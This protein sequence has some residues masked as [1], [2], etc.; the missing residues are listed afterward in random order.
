MDSVDPNVYWIF[1]VDEHS[2]LIG[3]LSN[4]SCQ[5]VTVAEK[6]ISVAFDGYRSCSKRVTS[7]M[8]EWKTVLGSP[9][10]QGTY[11]RDGNLSFVLHEKGTVPPDCTMMGPMLFTTMALPSLQLR[12]PEGVALLDAYY[13][14]NTTVNMQCADW[15][16]G[17]AL[18]REKSVDFIL[19]SWLKTKSTSL[20]DNKYAFFSPSALCY[21]VR[22]RV[23]VPPSFYNSWILFFLCFI[24]LVPFCFAIIFTFHVQRATRPSEHVPLSA[25]IMFFVMTFLGRSPH[26]LNVSAPA[27]RLVLVAWLLLMFFIGNYL[28]SSLTASRSMPA[29][30][31]EITKEQLLK[32]LQEG[33]ML[34]CVASFSFQMRGDRET[35]PVFKPLARALDK[36]QSRCL[37]KYGFGCMKKARRGTDVYF[38]MCVEKERRLAFMHGLV[39]GE[40]SLAAWQTYSAVHIRFPLRYQHKRLMMA[41]SESGIWMHSGSRYPLPP[42]NQD[43]V[44]L[45]IPLHE[46]L[47]VLCTGLAL[48]LVALAAEIL[49]YRYRGEGE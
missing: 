11:R 32:H 10:L 40:H 34:P 2:D 31:A 29:L 1:A 6:D 39:V 44:S 20:F 5:V 49:L 18:L 24:C 19:Y 9:E 35:Q 13:A 3:F 17:D 21:Y 14:I 27:P 22:G 12:H 43:I 46:Y 47:A 23:P 16:S 45:D 8:L 41:V 28:Q 7:S 33:T 4:H 25:V 38:N 30:S 26:G 37:D 42:V 36:C 15:S 48:S